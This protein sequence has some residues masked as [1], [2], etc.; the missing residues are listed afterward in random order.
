[1]N[2]Q[3][4]K[5]EIKVKNKRLDEDRFRQRRKEWLAE[6]PTGREVDFDEAIAYQKSLPPTKVWWKVMERL[7]QE[8][9]TV[10]SPRGGTATLE[11]EIKL[12]Q[13]IERSGVPLIPVTTDSYSRNRKFERAQQ[14]LEE[15]VRTGKSV[16]NGYPIAIHGV[17][18]TRKVI[19]SCD[20]AF[21]PRGAG[22]LAMEISIASGMT[23]GGGEIFIGFGSYD[24]KETLEDAIAGSQYNY[25]L[26]GWYAERGVIISYDSHGWVPSATFPLSINI[27][28]QIVECLSA[29]EQGVKALTPLV[30][31]M[32][33][34]AQD[35]AWTRVSPR[36]LR[37]YLDKCGYKDTMVTGRICQM[38]PL[39]PVPLDSGGAFAYINY[40]AMVASLANAE[41]LFVRTVDEGAGVAT[42]ETHEMSYRSAKWI[43]DVVREQKIEFD[44]KEVKTEEQ[45]TEA[46]VR[47]ILDK[48]FDL[49]D[50]DV[51]VGAVKGVEAGILDS[52][53][54]SNMHV[55]DKVLGVRDSRGA[56]RYLEFGNLPIP[57]EIKEFHRE[58][59]AEREKAEGK[60]VDYHTAV[61][62]L[63][64]F[65]KGKIVGLPPYNK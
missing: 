63:W 1:M 49:G 48:L 64:C 20:A 41:A 5:M 6:W 53:W 44:M 35:L 50:G 60:K 33:H 40:S 11:D 2:I 62:D 12:C 61:R 26:G 4:G 18:N 31:Y 13:S 43:F 32:G 9:R 57:E 59:V 45:I 23:A 58:K 36:L 10:V 15:S 37:E 14:A 25:R 27:A 28:C 19:E 8:G 3:G 38:I 17:K 51:L 22:G 34:M 24:K 42:R 55:K 65:S 7:R 39:F 16:L 56:C 54:S 52:P 30:H 21:S 47:A 46:E 29:A